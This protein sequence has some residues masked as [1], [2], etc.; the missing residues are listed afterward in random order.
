MWNFCLPQ[1]LTSVTTGMLGTI[2][3]IWLAEQNNGITEVAIFETARQ[4]QTSILFLPNIATQTLLPT[5]TEFYALKNKEMYL[6]TLKCNACVNLALAASIAVAVAVAAPWIM[7]A[8]GEGFETGVAT[9][10][11][12]LGVGVILSVGNVC[13]SALTSLGAIW[14]GF[15]LNAIYGGVFLTVAWQTLNRGG[16]AVGLASASLAAQLFYLVLCVGV[17]KRALAAKN[18]GE[19]KG[20]GAETESRRSEREVE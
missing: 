3:T 16:G 2:T 8:L 18:D 5:L 1:T 20:D 14:S 17:I 4:I 10:I 12:L 6:K 13:A 15:F 9:L 11:V 19:R 7:R